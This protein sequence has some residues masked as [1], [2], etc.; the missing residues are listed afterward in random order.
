MMFGVSQQLMG[1]MNNLARK[2]V[3]TYTRFFPLKKG[4]GRVV[5]A[6]RKWTGSTEPLIATV[7]NGYRMELELT[8]LIQRSIYFF[9]YYEPVFARFLDSVLRQN[10]TFIDCGA[11]IGQFSII[12]ARRVGAGGTVL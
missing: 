11:N 7:G 8:D 6:T 2:A 1:P 10:D 4:K 9:G 3:R 5:E 12:A